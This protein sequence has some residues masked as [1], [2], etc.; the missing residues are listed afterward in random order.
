MENAQSLADVIDGLNITA[1]SDIA[2]VGEQLRALIV[3][4]DRLRTSPTTRAA[5]ALSAEQILQR[6]PA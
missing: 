3:D 5:V 2:Y 4:P 6:I 1:N